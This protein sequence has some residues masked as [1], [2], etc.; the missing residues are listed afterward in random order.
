MVDHNKE[1]KVERKMMHE[2][3]RGLV[4]DRAES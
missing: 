1:R 4:V 2:E 3:L